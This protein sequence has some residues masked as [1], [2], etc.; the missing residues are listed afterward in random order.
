M[1]YCENPNCPAQVVGKLA[2]TFSKQGLNVQGLSEKTIEFL[3]KEHYVESAL[4]FYRLKDQGNGCGVLKKDM[5]GPALED[6]LGWEVKSVDNLLSAIEKSRDTTLQKFLYSLNI[7]LLGNDLSKKLS[8]FFHGDI[9][10]FIEF[11]QMVHN[12]KQNAMDILTSIEGIG[13]EK[14]TNIV[15]WADEVSAYRERWEDFM[16]LVQ[17]LHFPDMTVP[18]DKDNSLEGI[19]FVITG[20]VHVYHN[21]DEFK[22]SVEA[23]GGKVAGSVSKLTNYLVNNDTESTSSKNK[24]AKS[25]NIPIISEDEFIAKFGK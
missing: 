3:I 25:L 5:S 17:E 4:D 18:E 8:K 15:D 1:L 2:N 9:N 13:L 6:Q 24:K 11:I 16:A 23:R 21:R 20:S 22:E 10:G 14:A 12:D 19:T 7:P